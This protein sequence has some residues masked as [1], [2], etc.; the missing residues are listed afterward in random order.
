[1]VSSLKRTV[2]RGGDGISER[3]PARCA[4]ALGRR[5]TQRSWVR[6]DI[7]AKWP[8]IIPTSTPTLIGGS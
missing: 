6:D 3:H 8:G 7:S 5:P 2:F 4:F 1:L